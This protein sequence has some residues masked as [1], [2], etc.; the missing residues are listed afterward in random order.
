MFLRYLSRHLV[1]GS[2]FKIKKIEKPKDVPREGPP[3][4]QPVKIFKPANKK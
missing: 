2:L 3:V 4:N 1:P